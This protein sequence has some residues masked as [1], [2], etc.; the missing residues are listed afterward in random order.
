MQTLSKVSTGGII[1]LS[2]ILFITLMGVPPGDEEGGIG[3]IIASPNNRDESPR[4]EFTAKPRPPVAPEEPNPAPHI[5]PPELPIALPNMVSEPKVEEEQAPAYVEF[6]MPEV[7]AQEFKPVVITPEPVAA[8]PVIPNPP[9]LPPKPV[10]PTP[11]PETPTPE[12]PPIVVE[13]GNDWKQPQPW[14]YKPNPPT[15]EAPK[16]PDMTMMRAPQEEEYVS[17]ELEEPT[18]TETVEPEPE[19]LPVHETCLTVTLA[20]QATITVCHG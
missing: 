3:S 14:V 16:K 18:I 6:Y 4:S 13:K 15:H 2:G 11:E 8:P 10:E 19:P 17:P 9:V 7:L 12:K 1:V 5:R 20:E